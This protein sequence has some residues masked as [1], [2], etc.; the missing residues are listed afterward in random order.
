MA[1]SYKFHPQETF[2]KTPWPCVM[3]KS[4]PGKLVCSSQS[5]GGTRGDIAQTWGPPAKEVRIEESSYHTRKSLWSRSP[6]TKANCRSSGHISFDSTDHPPFLK[7]FFPLLLRSL[8]FLLPHRPLFLSLWQVL[9]ILLISNNGMTQG[10]IFE[11]SLPSIYTHSLRWSL[12]I[13]RI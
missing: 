4:M 1:I 7:Y 13:L 2:S 10:S 8:D 6:V 5:S 12:F 11:P 3:T 9:L